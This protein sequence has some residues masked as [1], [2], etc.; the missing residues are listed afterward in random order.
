MAMRHDERQVVLA[1]RQELQVF[2]GRTS[3]HHAQVRRPFRDRLDD[4]V[5]QPLAHLDVHVRMQ[6]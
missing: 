6:R 1:A 3:S 4:L 5:A 2:A